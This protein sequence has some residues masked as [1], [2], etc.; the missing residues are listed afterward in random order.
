MWLL[1]FI[2]EV[3]K[4]A[5]CLVKMESG[6]VRRAKHGLMGRLSTGCF[7][8]SRGRVVG[9]IP[10]MFNTEPVATIGLESTP[11]YKDL[12]ERKKKLIELGDAYIFS[13]RI[14]HHG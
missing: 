4:L 12:F 14:W 13:W 2:P 8:E 1:F 3:E 6:V 11:C 9:V 10:E 5:H 7:R